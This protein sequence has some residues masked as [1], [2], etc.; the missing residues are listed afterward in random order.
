M[1]VRCSVDHPPNSKRMEWASVNLPMNKQAMSKNRIRQ[2]LQSFVILNS[3]VWLG[4]DRRSENQHVQQTSQSLVVVEVDRVKW[5]SSFDAKVQVSGIIKTRRMSQISFERVGRVDTVSV[6]KG[7]RVRAGQILAE[8]NLDVINAQIRKLEAELQAATAQLSELKAGPLKV[9]IEAAKFSLDEQNAELEAAKQVLERRKRLKSSGAI[10]TEDLE[11]SEWAVKRLESAK[12]AAQKSLEEL[13]MGTRAEKIAT[14]EAVAK[15]IRESIAAARVEIEHSY[16][17]SPYD[18]TVIEKMV[19]EGNVANPGAVAFVISETS[20]LEAHFGCTLDVASRLNVNDQVE[21]EVRGKC[22]NG[23]LNSILPSVDEQTRTRTV[24]VKLESQVNDFVLPG[25]L[26]QLKLTVNQEIGGFWI[27]STALQQGTRGLWDCFVAQPPAEAA[28]EQDEPTYTVSKRPIEILQT[29][30]DRVLV[31][32]SLQEG[33]L[34]VS[35]LPSRLIAG[36]SVR[37]NNGAT[38]D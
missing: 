19:D 12:N 36:Q 8:L 29:Q 37:V 1:T 27:P 38:N 26:A 22:V 35:T 4:C 11:Q 16:V 25:D 14:Q 6:A 32:G 2:L 30:G 23:K 24:I 20:D 34:V 28:E 18:G 21:I 15:S 7:D 33:D 9:T 13:E 31:R 3:A 10:S 17:R 5:A